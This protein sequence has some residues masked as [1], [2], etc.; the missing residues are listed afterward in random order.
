MKERPLF[1]YELS[2][3]SVSFDTSILRLQNSPYFSMSF[4]LKS[5]H[6]GSG[7]SVKITSG[8]TLKIR[9]VTSSYIKSILSSAL[10][11]KRKIPIGQFLT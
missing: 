7:M 9:T 6:K 1:P 4:G 3:T 10:L 8:E 2:M 5:N 11:K